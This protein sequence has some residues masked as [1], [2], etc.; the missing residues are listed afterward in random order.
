MY[1]AMGHMLNLPALPYFD[2]STNPVDYTY[3]LLILTVIYFIYG[4]DIF[5][6]GMK[7]LLHGMPNMDTLVTLSVFCSLIYSIYGI[8]KVVSGEV[9]FIHNLAK[10]KKQ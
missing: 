8:I 9:H 6:S 4:V 7:N 3:L 10:Q 5:K 1:I 2:L